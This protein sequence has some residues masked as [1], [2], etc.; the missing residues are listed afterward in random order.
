MLGI[1]S[2][3]QKSVVGDAKT[4]LDRNISH[5]LQDKS[6]G[7]HY[8]ESSKTY[9]IQGFELYLYHEPLKAKV[10]AKL[11][12]CEKGRVIHVDGVSWTAYAGQNIEAIPV[13]KLVW[14]I[15]RYGNTL[16]VKPTIQT[17]SQDSGQIHSMR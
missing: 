1:I 10:E 16:L 14:V 11:F 17:S 5:L 8:D 6:I 3:R 12:P 15:G 9:M 13:G 7:I 4:T 2:S